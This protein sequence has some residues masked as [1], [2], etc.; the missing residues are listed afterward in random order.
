MLSLWFLMLESSNQGTMAHVE[1]NNENRFLYSF[2]AL[3]QSIVGFRHIRPIVTV[4]GTHLKEKYKGTIFIAA[5]LNGNEQIF[6]LAFDI[7]DSKMSHHTLSFLTNS[8]KHLA[9]SKD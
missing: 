8:Y 9:R 1:T 4:D 3:D 7:N 6:F 2:I 5:C